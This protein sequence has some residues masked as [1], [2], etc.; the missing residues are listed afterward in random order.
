MSPD[1]RG[2][3][4]IRGRLTKARQFSQAAA[5]FFDQAKG[6]ADL[7]DA[8]TTLAIH[9]GIASADVICAARTG[10]Y[11]AAD[12]HRAAISLLKQAQPSVTVQ[13]SRLLEMKTRAGYSHRQVSIRD[14]HTA[15]V[16]HEKLLLLAESIA[17]HR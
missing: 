12:S 14:V 9:S 2:S 1:V 3:D 15:R 13:L 6:T 4:F 7:Q 10:K 5:L 8:Y 11:S 17:S 16:A